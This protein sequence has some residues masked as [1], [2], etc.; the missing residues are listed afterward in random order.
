MLCR[1]IVCRSV[2][3]VRPSRSHSGHRGFRLIKAERPQTLLI[4][5]RIV[6]EVLYVAGIVWQ[7]VRDS[8][9]AVFLELSGGPRFRHYHPLPCAPVG[10]RILHTGQGARESCRV[11]PVRFEAIG[12][13]AP[14]RVEMGI[15]EAGNHGPAT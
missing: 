2:D 14:D 12:L 15:V 5:D 3:P 6:V 7:Q 11:V 13:S 8:G 10:G 9:R 1:R 4:Y